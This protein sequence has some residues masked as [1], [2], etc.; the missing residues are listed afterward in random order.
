MKFSV[1]CNSV[2]FNKKLFFKIKN[3]KMCE[4]V[5]ETLITESGSE[6]RILEVFFFVFIDKNKFYKCLNC[7]CDL[8]TS[9]S[10]LIF[11]GYSGT[12][13]QFWLT[14]AVLLII[15]VLS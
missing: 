9:Q 6:Y 11:Q 1:I 12:F 14:K 10:F 7:P 8:I 13:F 3:K 4:V 15:A 5:S 2:L